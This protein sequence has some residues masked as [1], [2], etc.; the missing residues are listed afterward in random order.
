MLNRMYD[1]LLL[2][3]IYSWFFLDFFKYGIKIFF[4][5]HKYFLFNTNIFY[6]IYTDFLSIKYVSL[7]INTFSWDGN[8]FFLQISNHV[9]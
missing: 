1:N 3:I 4:N 8:T 5:E 6:Q 2:K 7:N 9:P